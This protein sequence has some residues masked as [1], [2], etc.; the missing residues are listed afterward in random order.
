MIGTPRLRLEII[1]NVT[2]IRIG[3]EVNVTGIRIGIGI[4]KTLESH[5]AG[6][7]IGIRI[8]D[9][10]KSWYASSKA[11]MLYFILHVTC[12]L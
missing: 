6:I 5:D 2:G 1:V 4:S 11:V 7:G 8:M 10:E 3:I 9:F 12:P